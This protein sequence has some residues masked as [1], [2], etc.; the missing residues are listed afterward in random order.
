MCWQWALNMMCMSLYAVL[1]CFFSRTRLVVGLKRN[2]KKGGNTQVAGMYLLATGLASS[3][4]GD[5]ES[6][7][8]VLKAARVVSRAAQDPLL[9]T[10]ILEQ[11]AGEGAVL[12][13]LSLG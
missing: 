12:Y 8:E 2:Y 7:K 6:A 11:I 3:Q 13:R 10:A 9:G 4:A 5:L 1:P